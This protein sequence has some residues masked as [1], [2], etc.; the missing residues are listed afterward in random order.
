MGQ[1]EPKSVK[2]EDISAKK[3]GVR[4]GIYDAPNSIPVP[5][6]MRN[7]GWTACTTTEAATKIFIGAETVARPVEGAMVVRTKGMA[8]QPFLFARPA[9]PA[10]GYYRYLLRVVTADALIAHPGPQP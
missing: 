1:V 4:I 9:A 10:H 7:S 8:G 3:L 5:S 6:M 2:Q